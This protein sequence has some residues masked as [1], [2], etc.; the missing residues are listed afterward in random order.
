[1]AEDWALRSN[2]LQ[3]PYA[4]L[5]LRETPFAIFISVA[6]PRDSNWVGS[7]FSG[8]SNH[9]MDWR[10]FSSE[11][12][13]CCWPQSEAFAAVQNRG[14]LHG[15]ESDREAHPMRLTRMPADELLKELS[16]ILAVQHFLC[17]A[18]HE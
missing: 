14:N 4:P 15:Q 1:V 16:S 12:L 10:G 13:E 17:A 11:G 9:Y 2:P 6:E 18:Q 7:P 8:I 3:S 5:E